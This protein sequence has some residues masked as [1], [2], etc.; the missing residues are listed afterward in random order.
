MPGE[1]G[2]EE[3]GPPLPSPTSPLSPM[4][5]LNSP[6]RISGFEVKSK[7]AYLFTVPVSLAA[8]PLLL[9]AALPFLAC[10]SLLP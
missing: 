4:L 3:Q 1:M 8:I 9:S 2:V 7:P 10:M 5:I 6:W